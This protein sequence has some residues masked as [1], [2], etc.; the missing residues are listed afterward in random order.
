MNDVL[1]APVRRFVDAVAAELEGLS[2]RATAGDRPG[3]EDAALDAGAIV[4]GCIDADGVHTDQELRAYA[5]AFGP[6]LDLPI[7]YAK[8][9]ELRASGTITG[10]RA[11]L[12]RPSPLF[13]L[14]VDA[15]QRDG[16]ARSWVYYRHAMDLAHTVVSIDVHTSQ[17][18]LEAIGRLRGVLLARIREAGIAR[19][20]RSFFGIHPGA[21][22]EAERAAE[23]ADRD[24]RATRDGAPTRPTR[25]GTGR[26]AGAA[27]STPELP[28]ARPIEELMAELE[29]LVGLEPVKAEVRLVTNLLVVQKLRQERGLPSTPSS[30]HLVFTGNPGTGKTTVARLLAE[31]Y[32]TLGVVE[33]GHLVET[34][35]S[36][37]VAGFIGQTAERTRHVIEAAVGGVLLIDEAYA[38]ARGS[39][40]DFGREAVDTLVKRMEDLRGDLVVIAAG[41]PTEMATFIGAN[42]GLRSRFPRTI[43]FP[44]YSD[45]ELVRIFVLIAE[46]SHYTVDDAAEDVLAAWF[47][48]QPRDQG[49]GNGRLARNLFEAAVARQATRLVELDEPTDEQLVTLTAADIAGVEL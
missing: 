12:D 3:E 47:A 32:R 28:P 19:P 25:V 21:L 42:P 37:L 7:A 8:P 34:D 11:F 43:F 31:I 10:R 22:T 20:G 35:R 14:L 18:E 15:D 2:G 38:L 40:Q 44:D 30:R 33:R 4:A 45:E 9:D 26:S 41:Y 46:R 6:L 49:F 29:D 16:G 23:A 5:I 36:A 13:E 27:T 1:V 39:E 17:A 24:R 48:A